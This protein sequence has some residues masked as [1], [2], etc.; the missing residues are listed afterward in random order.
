MQVDIWNIT[1]KGGF[2]FGRHGLGQEESHPFLNSDTLFAALIARLALLQG[3]QAVDAWLEPFQSA[4][5]PFVVS[6]AFPRIGR[7]RFYPT[8]LGGVQKTAGEDQETPAKVLKK[9]R[10]VSESIFLQLLGE[11]SLAQFLSDG[12][13]LQDGKLLLRSSEFDELPKDIRR[14]RKVWEIE[15]RPRV[16]I[17]RITN[18][19]SLYHTGRTVFADGCGLWFGIRWLGSNADHLRILPD[20]MADLGDAGL[21]GERSSGLGGAKITLLESIELPDP[22]NKSWVTLSRYL[23]QKDEMNALFHASSAYSLETVGGWV[24]SPA[25]PAQRRRTVQMLVEGSVFGPLPRAVPGQVVDVKPIYK[26]DGVETKPLH[27]PVWRSGLAFAVGMQ[28]G[29]N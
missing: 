19:G 16:T 4:S 13:L 8:P 23:P 11:A 5:P 7:L 26:V 24:Q 2:H 21:G 25:A 15:R 28:T 1:G 18:S 29:D 12:E 10:F 20:L 6:S 14:I 17:D 22:N 9:I 27:H 3:A